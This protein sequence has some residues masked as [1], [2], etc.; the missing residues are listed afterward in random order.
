MKKYVLLLCCLWVIS[1]KKEQPPLI[2]PIDNNSNRLSIS[3]R[4]VATE[5]ESLGVSAF[6]V[7]L[8]K[9]KNENLSNY[10]YMPDAQIFV[11]E[12]DNNFQ[13]ENL[14]EGTYTLIITKKGYKPKIEY[15]DLQDIY[16]IF[17]TVDMYIDNDA[18]FTGKMQILGE[19][20]IDIS[21]ITFFRN[22]SS[23]FFYL[24]NGKGIKEY[25]NLWTVPD[26]IYIYKSVISNGEI[27]H[28]NSNWVKEI[29]PSSSGM[30]NPNEIV[31]IEIVIDPILYIIKEHSSCEISI[32]SN[33]KLELSY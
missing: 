3:G 31:L 11:T 2:E 18:G 19:D 6:G 22:T 24:F 20:G 21:E 26:E 10:E 9:E 16:P 27:V 33:L 30:L 4:I 5:Y 7:Q 25:Y 13:F 12:K 17:K 14:T 8:I 32:D 15:I 29:K 28:L 1:C 23:V